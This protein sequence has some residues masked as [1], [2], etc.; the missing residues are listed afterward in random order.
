MLEFYPQI[1]LFH[2]S[3]ALLSGSLFCLRG[4]MMLAG[5]RHYSHVVLRWLSYTIDTALLTAALMLMTIIHQYPFEQD[6]LTLKVLLIM[7]YIGL[8]LVA[9]RFATTPRARAVSFAAALL[10]FLFTIS[11]AR[12][13]H[14]LGIFHD[15]FA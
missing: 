1:R 6:W 14:P 13:H 5:S 12:A 11:V 3:C 15:L 4:L 8:G 9:L 2:I 7:A 10:V